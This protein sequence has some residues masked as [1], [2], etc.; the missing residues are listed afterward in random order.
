MHAYFCVKHSL[1]HHDRLFHVL[2]LPGGCEEGVH[3]VIM[4][5]A[6]CDC[7]SGIERFKGVKLLIDMCSHHHSA[8]L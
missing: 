2:I 8:F 3:D 4:L 5:G 1:L 7:P 6:V